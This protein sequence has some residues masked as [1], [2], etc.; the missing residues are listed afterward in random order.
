MVSP[1]PAETTVEACEGVD[2][3][4]AML[5]SGSKNLLVVLSG[6]SILTGG[7]ISLSLLI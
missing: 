7:I 4:K 1:S 5:I 3:M 2:E 6:T